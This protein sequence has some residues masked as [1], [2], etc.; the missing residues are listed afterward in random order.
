MSSLFK[1]TELRRYDTMEY[2]MAHLSAL[3]DGADAAKRKVIRM[4]NLEAL[5]SRGFIKEESHDSAFNQVYIHPKTGLRVSD[6]IMEQDGIWRLIDKY[7][8][9]ETSGDDALDQ[10]DEFINEMQME[11]YSRHL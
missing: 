8:Q 11:E 7:L 1:N 2:A 3:Y 5:A 4:T 10:K 6:E 9:D